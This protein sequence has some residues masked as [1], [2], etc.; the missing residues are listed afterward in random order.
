MELELI[1]FLRAL[2]PELAHT[3]A[4]CV[5][6]AISFKGHRAGECECLGRCVCAPVFAAHIPSPL[7]SPIYRSHFQLRPLHAR[8]AC[9]SV[10]ACIRRRENISPNRSRAYY[11]FR[12][13]LLL[14]DV[15]VCLLLAPYAR[16]P[17]PQPLASHTFIEHLIF[18]FSLNG[19]GHNCVL[20]CRS[21]VLF[22][23]FRACLLRRREKCVCFSFFPLH[24]PSAYQH[25]QWLM[26]ANDSG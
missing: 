1:H 24:F 15:C 18:K 9:A 4:D 16:P 21:F 6:R 7:C 11:Y 2:W 20:F 10:S 19:P 25:W 8:D 13:S 22:C 26:R 12:R 14:C 3:E 5:L 17:K 23:M